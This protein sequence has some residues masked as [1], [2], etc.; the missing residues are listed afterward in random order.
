MD[1]TIHAR[2]LVYE[3]LALMPS[4]YQSASLKTMLVLF[5]SAR[6]IALPEHT[7]HKPP[8][9]LSRFLNFYRWPTRS[10]IRTLRR[11]ALQTLLSR[12]EAGRRPFLRAIV[13]LTPLQK[14]GS[15]D[16]LAG[17]VHVLNKKRGLQ[18]VVPYLEV[19]GWRVPWSFRLW[20]GKDSV[21]PSGDGVG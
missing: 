9:A 19:D 11:V 20:R 8:S 18:L 5:L 13:G 3:L 10:L 17:L 2:K 16:G 7:S 14:S 4:P 15:F 6:G 1:L 12:R 21:P